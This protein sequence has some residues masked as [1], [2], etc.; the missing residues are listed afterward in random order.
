MRR[1]FVTQDEL[2]AESFI[3][4]MHEMYNVDFIKEK[5]V[6]TVMLPV[7]CEHQNTVDY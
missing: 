5:P 1:L 7:T 3:Q 6:A 2:S 4:Y